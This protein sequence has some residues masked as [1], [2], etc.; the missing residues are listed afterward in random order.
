MTNKKKVM[1]SINFTY[2]LEQI[3]K[4]HSKKIHLHRKLF[5]EKKK[6]IAILSQSNSFGSLLQV[7]NPMS[8]QHIVTTCTSL[9]WKVCGYFLQFPMAKNRK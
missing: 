3:T 9:L 4:K 2:F 8:C 1:H 6:K 5:L 7:L